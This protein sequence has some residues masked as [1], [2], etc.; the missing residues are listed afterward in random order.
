MAI[1][2]SDKPLG[3]RFGYTKHGGPPQVTHYKTAGTLPIYKGDVVAQADGR[4]QACTNATGSEPV[5]VAAGYT[6]STSEETLLPVYDDLRNT[7]FIAQADGTDIAGTS[8]CGRLIYYDI[9]YGTAT[10]ATDQSVMEIDS[11]AS[12]H[13]SVMLIDKVNRPDNVWGGNVDL[14]CQIVFDALEYIHAPAAS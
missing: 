12:T 6:A 10:T 1:T 5:G 7:V 3:F 8:L 2:N 13:N 14:F 4:I 11:D 9:N